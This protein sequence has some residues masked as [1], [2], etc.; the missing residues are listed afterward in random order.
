MTVLT[1][2]SSPSP[3]SRPYLPPRPPASPRGA[4][5]LPTL[6]AGAEH[7]E[8]PEGKT[9]QAI[10]PD[11][12]TRRS[13]VADL[14][15]ELAM[16]AVALAASVGVARLIQGGLGH[17]VLIPVMVTVLAGGSVTAVSARKGLPLLVVAALGVV[18]SVLAVLWTV[19]PGATRF[20]LP[21]ITTGHVV[22]N[23]I[24]PRE[25]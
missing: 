1:P 13:P 11:D 8:A 9:E 5:P 23:E 6:R 10:R 15:V 3:S 24:H 20:G 16:I 7:E 25:P 22:A 2:P 14:V 4:S 18:A 17:A 19:V 21:T 12:R